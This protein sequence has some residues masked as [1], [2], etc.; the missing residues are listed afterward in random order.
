MIMKKL[1][2]MIVGLATYV[3][4]F[5]ATETTV[6]YT[7]P[8][9]VVGSYTVKLNVNFKG[10]GDGDDWHAYTMTKTNKTY[11]GKY[12]YSCT[13]TDAW[14]GVG[15]MQIQLYDGETFKSQEVPFA[16]TQDNKFLSV[17]NYNGKM[18]EYGQT[19]WRTYNYDKTVTIHTKKTSTWTP[20]NL[21]N[22]FN[23][24]VTG[25]V[26]E[27]GFPGKATTQSTLNTDW[28]DYTITGRPCTTA[29]AS[30][31]S[32]GTG[33]QSGYITIG[34]ES[35]YWVTYDG[36]KTTC[37]SSV[38]ADYNY[39]RTVTSGKFGTICLPYAATVTGATVFK[40]VSTIGSGDAMT[41]I[42]LQPVSELVAGHAYIFKATST[43]LTATFSGSYS[44]AEEYDG[45]M[46]N[47][48]ATIQAPLGSYVVGTDNLIHKVTGNSVNVG[49]YKGYITLN[50]ITSGARSANFIAFE[51]EATGIESVQNENKENVMFNLQ[52]QRVNNAQKGLVIVG[53]K[54]MIRK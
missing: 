48:S 13:Y 8:A 54:K 39:T 11:F 32:S 43:T 10:W 25:D 40:I 33:N 19:Q 49:Q 14:D 47:L 41:G 12:I 6:Y 36:S 38:P 37:V 28:Y 46:G 53:G 34:D 26:A 15:V 52:G 9:D 17:G 5:A 7:V 22:Y 3:S 18:Y 1:L 44:A 29:I 30:N 51:D 2:L 31:G 42:N 35:E 4:S 23:D 20:T 21:H 50:G 24:G 45:M 27:Q 16:C